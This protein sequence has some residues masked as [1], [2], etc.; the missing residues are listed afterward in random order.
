M[1]VS[2][3]L[4]KIIYSYYVFDKLGEIGSNNVIYYQKFYD[5]SQ[6]RF[7]GI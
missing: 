3:K 7:T 6:V 2:V 5:N 1:G 4:W